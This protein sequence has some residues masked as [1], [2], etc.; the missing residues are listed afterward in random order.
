MK[1]FRLT[2]RFTNADIGHTDFYGY[3]IFDAMRRN[4]VSDYVK[5]IKTHPQKC[6]VEVIG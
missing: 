4:W 3:N 1:H 2:I 6:K 5:W